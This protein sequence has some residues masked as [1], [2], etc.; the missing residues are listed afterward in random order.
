MSRPTLFLGKSQSREDVLSGEYNNRKEEVV[1][2]EKSYR[3]RVTSYE[4]Q[5]AGK[6]N[7]QEKNLTIL[8]KR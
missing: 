1:G 3:V 4:L 7:T 6:S 5:N 2:G 8:R